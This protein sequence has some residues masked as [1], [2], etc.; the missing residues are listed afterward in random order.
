MVSTRMIVDRGSNRQCSPPVF[1][2]TSVSAYKEISNSYRTAEPGV[3]YCSR[4][5]LSWNNLRI[6]NYQRAQQQDQNPVAF[7]ENSGQRIFVCENL[8]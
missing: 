3:A 7:S 4:V 8:I 5:R 1:S 2:L 6:K